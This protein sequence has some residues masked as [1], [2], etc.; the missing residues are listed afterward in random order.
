[1]RQYGIED[2]VSFLGAGDDDVLL[3]KLA[4]CR[5]VCFPA[6]NEDYGLVTVEAFASGKAVITCSDSGGPAEL[7]EE[8]VSGI[9]TSPNAS[10]LAKALALGSSD[11]AMAE[12][13]GAGGLRQVQALTWERVFDQLL[14]V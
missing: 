14:L 12:R 10:S 13:L 6:I 7:V 8:N 3:T 4:T 1:M 5:A 9:V 2:R 11:R